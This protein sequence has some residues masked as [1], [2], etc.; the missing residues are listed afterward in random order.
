MKKL[1]LA[2]LVALLSMG[3][4]AQDKKYGL[5]LNLL[6]GTKIKTMGIGVKGQLYATDVVRVEANAAYFLKNNEFSWN[7]EKQ[8]WEGMK[9]WDVNVV[10]HYLVNVSQQKAWIYP[11]AGI[12][13]SNWVSGIFSAKT[14]FTINVGAGFQYDVADDF[15]INAEAK[16]QINDGYNQA[17]LGIG[18]VYKF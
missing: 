13:L 18:A 4:S 11:L 2:M 15:A 17:I 14:R 8:D 12:G 1:F 9:M 6:Y 7:D 16:Y 5:G 10:G 3:A